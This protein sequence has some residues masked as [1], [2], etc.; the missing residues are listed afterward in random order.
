ATTKFGEVRVEAAVVE[1]RR[2]RSD[3]AQSVQ[4][5]CGPMA[6]P[7]RFS[8]A[9]PFVMRLKCDLSATGSSGR[10]TEMTPP[11]LCVGDVGDFRSVQDLAPRR[12]STPM[13]T[14]R[15]FTALFVSLLCSALF[16]TPP[17]PYVAL[18]I[19]YHKRD[20]VPAGRTDS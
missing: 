5:V 6:R 19:D 7:E 15:I 20:P 2:S 14:I 1:P 18:R 4:Q 17:G 8:R 3:R 11:P 13:P 12:I 16:A 10:E 9:D